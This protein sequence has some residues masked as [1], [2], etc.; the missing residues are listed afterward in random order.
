MKASGL[1]FLARGSNSLLALLTDL[2]FR[3]QLIAS[4]E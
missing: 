4:L 1:F 2:G 3:A